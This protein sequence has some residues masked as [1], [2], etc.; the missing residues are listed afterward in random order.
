[1][2][3]TPSKTAVLTG[4]FIGSEQLPGAELDATVQVVADTLRETAGD[5]LLRFARSRGDGWQAALAPHV[6]PL[7]AALSVAAALRADDA[8]ATRT[9]IA[10]GT[11]LDD[12]PDDLNAATGPTFT[13]SGRALD[14]L[15]GDRHIIDASGGA[16]DACARL[17]D[18][19]AQ[20]WTAA[21]ARTALHLLHPSGPTRAE[22]AERIG[23]SRQAVDKSAHGAQLPAILDALEMIEPT[24]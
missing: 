8:L 19:I 15:A 9:A 13:A 3:A 7:R 11:P 17:A 14:R 24:P 1:M 20:T 4:D 10:V 21:Q 22:V 23:I 5:G 2:I 12:L 18:A 16:L 6:G